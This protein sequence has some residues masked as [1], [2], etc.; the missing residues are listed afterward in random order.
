MAV[1]PR[2]AAAMN[3]GGGRCSER[4]SQGSDL[5]K[6]KTLTT[7]VGYLGQAALRREQCD[8]YTI[9]LRRRCYLVTARQ[10]TEE[11]GVTR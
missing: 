9:G 6:K 8:V 5:E 1:V 11:E 10:A 4:E 2:G 3:N 7:G